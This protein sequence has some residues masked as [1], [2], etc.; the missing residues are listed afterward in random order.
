MKSL[1]IRHTVSWST[2]NTAKTRKYI[3]TNSHANTNEITCPC[4]YIQYVILIVCLTR[5]IF[6]IYICM[7]V[8][9]CPCVSEYIR[10][11]SECVCECV[12]VFVFVYKFAFTQS[13]C[14]HRCYQFQ[15]SVTNK[16]THIYNSLCACFDRVFV[17]VAMYLC[18]Y[19]FVKDE[20]RLGKGI[21]GER[22]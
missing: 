9:V 10:I 12:Q 2:L 5:H 19:M 8:C 4:H 17:S 22:A 16:S 14:A 11:V 1:L 15:V 3:Y 18:M 13:Y 21:R 20:K 6:N 7:Y